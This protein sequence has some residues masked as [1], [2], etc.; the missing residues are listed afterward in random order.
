MLVL[1]PGNFEEQYID[2]ESIVL[3]WSTRS[4]GL[5]RHFAEHVH[6]EYTRP[7]HMLPEDY[8]QFEQNVR[9]VFTSDMFNL[10]F[11]NIFR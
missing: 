1:K 4:E 3:C 8:V 6:R 10:S 7:G 9:D 11:L 5:D 2:Y